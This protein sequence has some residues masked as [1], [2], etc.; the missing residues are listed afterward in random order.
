MALTAF[1]GGAMVATPLNEALLQHFF[2]A[3]TYL[4]VAESLSLV[5]QGGTRF[6]Q[7][8]SGELTEVVIASSRDVAQLHL[9]LPAGVYE[10]GTGNSGVKET[11]L[12]LAALHT[13]SM[14][15][16]AWGQRV[17]PVNWTPPV[18]P[19]AATGGAGLPVV[20]QLRPDALSASG[21]VSP[22]QALKTP[23]FYLLWA[24]VAGNA[25]AGVSVISCAKT[26]MTD[27]F[28]TALPAVVTAGFAATY[29]AALSAANM[30]GRL[31]W[32]FASDFL[33]RK[34]TYY[35]FA[36]GIPTVLCL[37]AL[38]EWAG[39]APSLAPLV[40]FYGGTWLVVS[41]YGGVF[42]VLPAYLSDLFGPKHVGAI[43]GRLL[44]A[45]AAAAAGGPYLLA[46]LRNRS[47]D[48]AVRDLAGQVDPD[49][50]ERTFGAPLDDLQ[51]LVASKSVTIPHLMDIMPAGVVDPTPMLN[52]DT[53]L[54]MGGLLTVA[55]ACN[56]GIRPVHSKHYMENREVVDAQFRKVP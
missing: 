7:L 13:A 45:W 6:V 47:Y 4:G 35:V 17:P 12:A 22:D 1:G 27:C 37:P 23:Q 40:L 33:G 50:F 34:N 39:A 3:P 32:S 31:G 49:A 8:P 48:I 55:L 21:N 14:L 43:H 36:A 51:E 25:I 20:Q 16:G 38:T 41:F 10:V 56:A 24:A 15:T 5:T 54:A 2:E 46:A 29:V 26:L 53:M 19:A 9:P 44:T 52:N 28:S 42:S 11:F 18:T 30:S